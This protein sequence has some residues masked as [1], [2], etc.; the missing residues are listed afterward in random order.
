[1]AAKRKA[2]EGRVARAILVVRVED[3]PPRGVHVLVLLLE[4]APALLIEQRHACSIRG[5][6][7]GIRPTALPLRC[8]RLLH[9]A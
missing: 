5:A 4:A 2:K 8:E 3:A 9:E 1:M 6:R 7:R